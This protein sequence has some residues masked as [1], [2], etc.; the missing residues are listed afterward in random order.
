M[1]ERPS[2]PGRHAARHRAPSSLDRACDRVCDGL[3]R[4]P[5]PSLPRTALVVSAA[6]GVLAAATVVGGNPLGGGDASSP[7]AAVP[8]AA[9]S[10]A[11]RV[12]TGSISRDAVRPSLGALKQGALES[13]SGAAGRHRG[14]AE[15][16]TEQLVGATSDPRDIARA[17]LPQYGWSEYEFS[18]LDALWIG[19][20][21]WDPYATNPT[22]GAYGIPQSL[23]AEKMASAGP[24]WRT[25]PATQIEWGLWYI[26]VSYGT[27]C[28]ANAFKVANG[29][30]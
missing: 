12:A 7:P 22:S 10:D 14:A 5:R 8:T 19:E 27:P 29:W 30:Y 3:E 16:A 20:S 13:R 4:L 9:A 1:A 28:S 21:D 2:A 18:C 24:D 15:V 17:M 26:D 25:N 6:G 23:P 11:R